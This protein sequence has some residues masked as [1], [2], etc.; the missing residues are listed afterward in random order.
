[1]ALSCST[2]IDSF[3]FVRVAVGLIDILGTVNVNRN[4][5]FKD[6]QNKQKRRKIPKQTQV[7]FLLYHFGGIH[8]L[9][10]DKNIQKKKK[11]E[12]HLEQKYLFTV[13]LTAV[14]VTVTATSPFVFLF[15]S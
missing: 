7:Y 2:V 10:G 3:L 11:I 12:K 15:F 5:L 8:L 9:L 1:M 6:L 4:R 13:L 14:T